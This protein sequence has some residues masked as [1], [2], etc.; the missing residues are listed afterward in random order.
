VSLNLSPAA[1]G[2]FLVTFNVCNA[3]GHYLSADSHSASICEYSA[4]LHVFETTS[5]V[6][7][8]NPLSKPFLIAV[9]KDRPPQF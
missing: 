2:T 9:Q 7:A 4:A 1:N 3:G 6:D 5:L 8:F